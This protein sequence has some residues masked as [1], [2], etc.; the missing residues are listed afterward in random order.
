M[1]WDIVCKTHEIMAHTGFLIPHGEQHYDD[2]ELKLPNEIDIPLITLGGS[3]DDA[4]KQALAD[5]IDPIGNLDRNLGLLVEHD[6][7]D[8]NYPYYTA[9][10]V[11]TNGDPVRGKI[12]PW[13]TEDTMIPEEYHRPWAYPDQSPD[14]HLVLHRTPSEEYDATKPGGDLD[15]SGNPPTVT[16]RPLS[17]PYPRK[18]KPDVFFGDRGP[19]AGARAAYEAARTP[20]ETDSLNEQHLLSDAPSSPLG[21]PVPF[22]AYLIGR[23][24]NDTGYATQFNLDSDRAYAYLTWDW[25]RSDETVRADLPFDYR[26][27]NT[28]PSLSKDW[29]GPLTKMQLEYVDQVSRIFFD[30]DEKVFED[31]DIVVEADDGEPDARGHR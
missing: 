31:I 3:A 7:T 21:D 13:S 25:I 12:A 28:W 18:A 2:G 29:A 20:R 6:V 4:F 1:A 19:D 11:D 10:K 26:A 14:E 24:A 16:R 5:A 27:P 30:A 22:S 8:P 23:L 17:G 15:A 9:M